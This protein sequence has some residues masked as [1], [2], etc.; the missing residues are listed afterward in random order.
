[1]NYSDNFLVPSPLQGIWRVRPLLSCSYVLYAPYKCL[2]Y[3]IQYSNEDNNKNANE[4]I[5][6]LITLETFACQNG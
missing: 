2:L 5:G 4:R 1:M 6:E 3:T